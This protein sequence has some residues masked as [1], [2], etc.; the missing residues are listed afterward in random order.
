MMT[1]RFEISYNPASRLLL[2]LL[3]AGP[4]RSSVEVHQDTVDARLGWVGGVQIP[5]PAI[6]SVERVDRIPWWLGW[7]LHSG[8]RGVWALN[9]SSTGAVL[10]TFGDGATGKV[11]GMPIRP[12]KVYLSLEDP[13]GFI[14]TVQPGRP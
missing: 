4:G 14:A 3:G 10:L 5:R 12:R 6:T 8:F 9:G 7:G 13:H 11:L 1:M 2:T